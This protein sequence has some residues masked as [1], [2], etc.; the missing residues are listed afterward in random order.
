MEKVPF[1]IVE[2]PYR[3]VIEQIRQQILHLGFQVNQTFD[4]QEA[5]NAHTNCP[6]P[7]HGA[8]QC[9]C[10]LVIIL[11]YGREAEPVTLVVHGYEG[12]TW[13]SFSEIHQSHVS[14]PVKTLLLRTLMPV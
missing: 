3:I 8:E 11:V 14:Q 13:F 4:L 1:L 12:K 6:C 5:R 9:D 10:Q 2:Q 7:Y